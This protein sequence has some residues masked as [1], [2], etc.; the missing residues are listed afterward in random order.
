MNYY[1]RHG[2]QRQTVLADLALPMLGA[3]QAANAGVAL[4]TCERLR[5]QGTELSEISLRRG[6]ERAYSPG[7]IEVLSWHPTVIIDTAH[8]VASVAALLAVLQSS[9]PQRPRRLV[10]GT[11]RGKD[12]PGMLRLLVAYFD[13][14]ICTCYLSNLR[15]CPRR[16]AATCVRLSDESGRRGRVAGVSDAR[17]SVAGRPA[18][19]GSRRLNL[20]D[21]IVLHRRRTAGVDSPR[22]KCRQRGA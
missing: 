9:F 8:N 6:L 2:Q 20:S 19:R 17:R 21:G 1:H 3:H 5:E 13:Q 22:A 18:T 10:F 11:T 15:R 14:I 16:T 7:R 4:A 12:V